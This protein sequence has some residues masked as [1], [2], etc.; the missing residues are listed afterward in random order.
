MRWIKNQK[1]FTLIELLAVIIILA[2]IALIAV[3]TI[4]SIIENS[5]KSAAKDSAYAYAD[6]V[7]KSVIENMLD[8]PTDY[9]LPD[10]TYRVIDEVGSLC[11]SAIS[12]AT[13]GNCVSNGGVLLQPSVKG[14][15]PATGGTITVSNNQVTGVNLTING[16][17]VTG[18]PNSADNDG[19]TAN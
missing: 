14:D 10:G 5:R 15:L 2:I 18:N 13:V 3:P 6:A 17:I 19:L 1:G 4:T 7:E 11:T 16:I 12:N 8:G 9:S